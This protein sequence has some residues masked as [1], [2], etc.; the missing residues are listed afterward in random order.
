MSFASVS[1]LGFRQSR[2][3]RSSRI[4]CAGFVTLQEEFP[5]F[6]WVKLFPKA[7]GTVASR[8]GIFAERKVLDK[9]AVWPMKILL[10]NYSHTL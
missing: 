8:L 5:A 6:R 1:L 4:P 7:F 9:C 2:K 3:I 10:P